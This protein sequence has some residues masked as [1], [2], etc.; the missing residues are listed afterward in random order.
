MTKYFK[1]EIVSV[2]LTLN[3]TAFMAKKIKHKEQFQNFNLVVFGGTG[4]LALRKIYPRDLVPSRR[5]V[6]EEVIRRS[7]PR[8][9]IGARRRGGAAQA[10]HTRRV[11]SLAARALHCE[12]RSMTAPANGEATGRFLGEEWQEIVPGS[13][14]VSPQPHST[15]LL[16]S[17]RELSAQCFS[18][19]LE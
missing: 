7:W 18:A 9:L 15:I 13:L 11:L 10:A 19:R 16:P 6:T 14:R 8:E 1:I 4:D 2:N 5:S 17:R 12:R 3:K